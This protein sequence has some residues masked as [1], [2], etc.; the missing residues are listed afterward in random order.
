V[1]VDDG[2]MTKDATPQLSHFAYDRWVEEDGCDMNLVIM[3]P[4]REAIE[5][6]FAAIMR[7]HTLDASGLYCK[8]DMEAAWSVVTKSRPQVGNWLNK[9]S[10]A[11]ARGD[12]A[13]VRRAC[14]AS[15][16]EWVDVYPDRLGV[17]WSS[18]ESEPVVR[19]L[20]ASQPDVWPSFIVTGNYYLSE[21]PESFVEDLTQELGIEAWSLHCSGMEGPITL[22]ARL[23]KIVFVLPML[24]NE[25]GDTAQP[26]L[27]AGIFYTD[28]QVEE[29]LHALPITMRWLL[30]TAHL[31]N[32]PYTVV[33]LDGEAMP[34]PVKYLA[35]TTIAAAVEE[36]KVARRSLTQELSAL[37]FEFCP[38]GSGLFLRGTS[39]PMDLLDIPFDLASSLS[40]WQEW[41]EELFVRSNTTLT[42]EQMRADF[43]QEAA[44]L[45][46]SLQEA[47]GANVVIKD[48]EK[49][50]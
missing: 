9:V 47:L 33:G 12:V 25:D 37:K 32:F 42:T 31:L 15:P 23:S 14:F 35:G 28:E 38:G 8:A 30:W 11:T 44:A 39:L 43:E 48:L 16:P 1:A 22:L 10:I 40:R 7:E 29:A 34:S 46:E 2:G 41:G 5:A 3:D 50:P 21:R 13:P 18:P 36:A 27:F 20:L 17:M 49:T 26:S 45:V 19:K 4:E 6:A 24:A